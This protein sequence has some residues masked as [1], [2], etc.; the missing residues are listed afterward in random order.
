MYLEQ[1]MLK[2][3]SDDEDSIDM[4]HKTDKSALA[5]RENIIS[6]AVPNARITTQK[7]LEEC[8]NMCLYALDA[9]RGVN[10]ITFIKQDEWMMNH[11]TVQSNVPNP[12]L[13]QV[14]LGKE[15][16]VPTIEHIESIPWS[17]SIGDTNVPFLDAQLA[18]VCALL[19]ADARR[20]DCTVVAVDPSRQK[21]EGYGDG[22]GD[23]DEQPKRRRCN[24]NLIENKTVFSH[25]YTNMGQV[26]RCL[27]TPV[28]TGKNIMAMLWGTACCLHFYKRYKD[29][30]AWAGFLGTNGHQSLLDPDTTEI[31]PIFIY[32]VPVHQKSQAI[33]EGLGL[34]NTWCN[35]RHRFVS[36]YP[37]G[38]ASIASQNAYHTVV[39]KALVARSM[40][41]C[42]M[43]IVVNTEFDDVYD[44][45]CRQV[46]DEGKH[47]LPLAIAMDEV[48][49][50]HGYVRNCATPR[51][52]G[53]TAT[54]L[55]IATAVRNDKS[56]SIWKDFGAWLYPW[57]KERG[58]KNSFEYFFLSND[59]K[60]AM[61]IIQS[62]VNFLSQDV[63]SPFT[64]ALITQIREKVAR[65]IVHVEVKTRYANP[66]IVSRD[67]SI[68]L[69]ITELYSSLGLKKNT[70][71]TNA[72]DEPLAVIEVKDA[73]Q[74]H[75]KSLYKKDATSAAEKARIDM[76]QEL[77]KR[78]EGEKV[79][80]PCCG[81]I[82]CPDKSYMDLDDIPLSKL[83]VMPCC[84][85]IICIDCKKWVDKTQSCYK[86][87]GEVKR[88]A[89]FN[90]VLMDDDP[91]L[92]EDTPFVSA[93]TCTSFADFVTYVH[94]SEAI[95]R[96]PDDPNTVL[97]F[98]DEARSAGVSQ[99]V[100]AWSHS[101]TSY[102]GRTLAETAPAN[103]NFYYMTTLVEK[104]IYHYDHAN[105]RSY[106]GETEWTPETGKE[107]IKNVSKRIAEMR[108]TPVG[109]I[110]V[111]IVRPGKGGCAT[112]E[113]MGLNLDNA[114]LVVHMGTY[115]KGTQDQIT[116]RILRPSPRPMQDKMV[117]NIVYK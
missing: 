8:S 41:G 37:D 99:A 98:F 71:E 53:V 94:E 100:L 105:K 32:V 90:E 87:R 50:G 24:R 116:G 38:M 103:I 17:F 49:G 16:Y 54:Q 111:I 3:D 73:A 106:T 112:Q 47:V 75:I 36:V 93:P 77:V 48:C 44:G 9:A 18:T 61:N 2:C 7:D 102:M 113:G 88:S 64:P 56:D 14:A 107:A 22:D 5:I 79:A 46:T 12:A 97:T 51:I 20:V 85:N 10:S 101:Q 11:W 83:L 21:Q 19:Y 72:R 45:I 104:E 108:A 13:V 78:L 81:N 68:K 76:L 23:F 39:Q 117:V 114:D 89:I 86:C 65:G 35:E 57:G 60:A 96:F 27:S 42:L 40:G 30:N 58:K 95:K 15:Y 25:P 28:G 4:L 66:L 92:V 70:D 55:E 67:P 52:L 80:C 29:L 115:S 91:R 33:I 59:K 34:A 62:N 1:H 109:H 82:M 84:S 43:Y 110:S 6:S 63:A 74:A 31:L 26:I 69:S